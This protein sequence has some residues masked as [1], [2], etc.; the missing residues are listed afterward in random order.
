MSN[1]N[2]TFS[3]NKNCF[4]NRIQNR[5]YT[6]YYYYMKQPFKKNI[7]LYSLNIIINLRNCQTLLRQFHQKKKRK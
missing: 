6:I 3:N 4:K 1:R 2:L 5:R 7:Y